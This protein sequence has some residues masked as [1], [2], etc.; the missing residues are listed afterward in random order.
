MPAQLNFADTTAISRLKSQYFRAVDTH[1]L[2]LLRQ[3]FTPDAEFRGYGFGIRSGVDSLI[4]SLRAKLGTVTSQH[5]GT[6]P[7]FKLLPAEAGEDNCAVA[8]W[9]FHDELRW[10]PSFTEL[11]AP[12]VAGQIGIRGGGYYQDEL[13]RTAEGWRIAYTRNSR[14][15]LEAITPT[16][17]VQLPIT[18][19]PLDAHWLDPHSPLRKTQ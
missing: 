8:L 14:T 9:T 1:S 18:P 4:D 2:E 10:E 17:T 6:N 5:R 13:V 7:E 11:N 19:R 12:G 16:A 15:F 3:V